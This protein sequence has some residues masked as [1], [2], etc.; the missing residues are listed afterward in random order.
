MST[1]SA[2]KSVH[3]N[4]AGRF[5]VNSVYE[6]VRMRLTRIRRTLDRKMD[7]EG[8]LW[9]N[10]EVDVLMEGV[11]VHGW[12]YESCRVDVP[13]FASKLR[14]S[15]HSVFTKLWKLATNYVEPTRA[16]LTVGHC[17]LYHPET[18]RS[19]RTGHPWTTADLAIV[20]FAHNPQGLKHQ[21]NAPA[22]LAKLLGRSELD[23][24]Q[25]LTK[26]AELAASKDHG[27]KPL[28]NMVS[29]QQTITDAEKAEQLCRLLANKIHELADFIATLKNGAG[30]KGE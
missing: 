21:A 7:R 5:S 12:H 13:C 23:V 16:D 2:K 28:L 29:P 1:H 11:L 27:L 18:G 3:Y 15:L 6:K 9:T 14:K 26:L 24:Q 20:V 4:P 8:K 10:A 30:E 17:D 19:E 25:K 22:R